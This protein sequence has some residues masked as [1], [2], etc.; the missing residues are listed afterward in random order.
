MNWTPERYLLV[1]YLVGL[2]VLLGYALSLW[3]SVRKTKRREAQRRD[4]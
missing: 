1:G 2:G 3:L 4:E